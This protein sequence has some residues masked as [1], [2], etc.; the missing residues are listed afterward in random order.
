MCQPQVSIDD[1]EVLEECIDKWNRFLVTLTMDDEV[2]E[3]TVFTVNLHLMKHVPDVMRQLGPIH[4]YSAFANERV[5]GEYK[6]RIKSRKE[7]GKNAANVLKQFAASYRLDRLSKLRKDKGIDDGNNTYQRNQ[8]LTLDDDYSDSEELWGPIRK[9]STNQFSLAVGANIKKY[10]EKYYRTFEDKRITINN[11]GS[12]ELASHL[13]APD[14][15]VY[16]CSSF[17]AKSKKP[18]RPSSYAAR[19]ESFF[20]KML[21]TID[22]NPPRQPIK[23]ERRAFFGE[24]L[25]YFRHYANE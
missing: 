23:L 10:L 18:T 14:G 16:D 3:E 7:P 4:S 20:V 13:W 21:L 6:R 5:I 24:V 17:P 2:L 1:I 11:G 9:M 12:I 15:S 19:R 25:C 22:V 8:V